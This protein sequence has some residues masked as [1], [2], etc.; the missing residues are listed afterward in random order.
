MEVNCHIFRQKVRKKLNLRTIGKGELTIKSFGCGR[1]TKVLD[2]VEFIIKTNTGPVKVEAFV[3][4]IS[5]PLRDQNTE[6]AKERYQ[7]IKSL[8]L[9]DKNN[10]DYVNIDILIGSNY[11][12]DFIDGKKIVKGACSNFVQFGLYFEWN[13]SK[14]F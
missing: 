3:S 11:Y 5:Y 6:V 2:V 1:Q 9:A 4:E 7:H 12:W 8:N 14:Q 13:S 10:E